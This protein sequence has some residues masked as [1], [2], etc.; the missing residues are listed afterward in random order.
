MTS[1]QASIGLSSLSH[2]SFSERVK[3]AFFET[4]CFI[5]LPPNANEGTKVAVGRLVLV[6][7]RWLLQ[8]LPYL[9]AEET[10][11]NGNLVR[12]FWFAVSCIRPDMIMSYFN[13]AWAWL[14]LVWVGVCACWSLFAIV[15]TLTFLNRKT[16]PRLR[17]LLQVF[18]QLL[19]S[20]ISIPSA[21][22]LLSS[23][24]PDSRFGN[25]I[26]TVLFSSAGYVSLIVY[27]GL[28]SFQCTMIIANFEPD[29]TLGLLRGKSQMDADF[30][31]LLV[32]QTVM[33]SYYVLFDSHKTL[34]NILILL[35]S[36][37]LML[38]Y[39]TQLPH[40]RPL[41]NGVAVWSR[42]A[43]TCSAL[44]ML[45]GQRVSSLCSLLLLVA[46]NVSIGVILMLGFENYQHRRIARYARRLSENMLVY[47]YELGIRHY[48][49]RAMEAA[50]D[51]KPAQGALAVSRV[52]QALR[53]C[54][55]SDRKTLILIKYLIYLNLLRNERAARVS[56]SQ[57]VM[58]KSTL[59]SSFLEFK[60]KWML[61]ASTKLE[62]IVFLRYLEKLD[63]VREKDEKLCH[64]LSDLWSELGCKRPSKAR[65]LL[66]ASHVYQ[67]VKFLKQEFTTLVKNFPSGYDLY[68]LYG[69]FVRDVLGKTGKAKLLE[70]QGKYLMDEIKKQEMKGEVES[71]KFFDPFAG[72]VLV[73]TH[74]KGLG[75]FL[76]MNSIAAN[77][78]GCDLKSLGL[79]KVSNLIPQPYSGPHLKNIK[80]FVETTQSTQVE[81]P[82]ILP[83]ATTSGFIV[84]CAVKLFLT[85]NNGLPL[86]ALAFK[87]LK[88]L[89]SG[90]ILSRDGVIQAHT[91][92]FSRYLL[93]VPDK[94]IE[95]TDLVALRNSLFRHR[96]PLGESEPFQLFS[97]RSYWG[98]FARVKFSSTAVDFF[99]VFENGNVQVDRARAT[100]DIASLDVKLSQLAADSSNG[101]LISSEE[102]VVKPEKRANFAQNELEADTTPAQATSPGEETQTF[103]EAQSSHHQ[104]LRKLHTV[105]R[106]CVY[107]N[108]LMVLALLIINV[109]GCVMAQWETQR[110]TAGTSLADVFRREMALL[111]VALNARLV[112][113][114][115]ESNQKY[116]ANFDYFLKLL[117]ETQANVWTEI[118]ETQSREY[119]QLMTR[120]DTPTWQFL[121]NSTQFSFK[122]LVDALQFVLDSV[123]LT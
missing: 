30:L 84:F 80:Q 63:G 47:E 81:H 1:S 31:T 72:I 37:P 79:Y 119:Q 36:L 38:R 115:D 53:C 103:P 18:G 51:C 29:F 114:F 88:S 10:Q 41:A 78:L 97:N 16:H 95:L 102:P 5:G 50:E 121:D 108:S 107:V 99:Y 69:S 45:V 105:H 96:N 112:T 11:D 64:R 113:K 67:E 106:F 35:V 24:F 75:S 85:S 98:K 34:H 62:E 21:N 116:R 110:V 59:T 13:L 57:A 100:W 55:D 87:P 14:I 8:L 3:A 118:A 22:I 111:Q 122:P 28:V 83:L 92:D 40:Y 90:A 54:P 9:E 123:C 61:T 26:A 70:L 12:G 20:L 19:L 71:V 93:N 15:F 39:Y 7:V 94:H 109:T 23:W 58:L 66:L 60:A 101:F 27:V 120:A 77:L 42:T 91:R 56:L 2:K 25:G 76:Y 65:V 68:D 46:L 32:A 33:V 82:S 6:E 4:V 44:A 73:D 43:L 86:L 17:K 48:I 104:L 49:F 117:Q 89:T 52:D 74:S